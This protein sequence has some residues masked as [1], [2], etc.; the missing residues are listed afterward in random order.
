MAQVVWTEPAVADLEAIADCIALD[1]PAAARE[2]IQRILAHVEQLTD[3][4]LSGPGLRGF[5][6]YRQLVEPPCRVV[7]RVDGDRVLILHVMRSEQR[8]RRSNLRR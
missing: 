3:F 2:L 6:G 8:L 7:Y 5:R 1:K 4:P